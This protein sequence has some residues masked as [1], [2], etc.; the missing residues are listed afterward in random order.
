MSRP[1][2]HSSLRFA[3]DPS[4]HGGQ[5]LEHLVGVVRH[6]ALG[7]VRRAEP[8]LP[9]GQQRRPRR[10]DQPAPDDLVDRAE[11][12]EVAAKHD[13]D[14]PDGVAAEERLPLGALRER[15]LQGLQRRHGPGHRLRPLLLRLAREEHP[16]PR[17]PDLV[18]DVRRPEARRGALV[19]VGRE[20]GRAGPRPDLVD[21][22]H[23]DLGLVHGAA[24]VEEDGHALVHRVGAQEERALAAQ[25]LL[26]V[27]VRQRLE[28]E[29]H[30]HPDDERARPHAQQLQLAVSRH[31]Q[32]LL[33]CGATN[34]ERRRR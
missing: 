11:P 3:G 12:A 29:H 21:V 33:M 1:H 19:G 18:V 31:W 7:R 28:V 15:A 27:L 30:A 26:H 5:E 2:R 17:R 16:R 14:E 34:G 8:L 25:A 13:V 10:V 23:D 22:L 20:H 32:V 6:D 9:P 4:E 24:A